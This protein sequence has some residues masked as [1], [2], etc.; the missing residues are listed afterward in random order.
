MS[1]C[2]TITREYLRSILNYDPET[3]VF[4]WAVTNSNRAPT[5]SV[6]GALA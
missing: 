1:E 6:A 4:T 2:N 5:G 3:G